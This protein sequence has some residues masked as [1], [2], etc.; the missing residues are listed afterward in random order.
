MLWSGP[1]NIAQVKIDDEGSLALLDSGSTINVVTPEFIKAHSLDMGPL[2]NLV[3]GTL[4]ING[5]VGLLSQP[6]GYVIVRV[7]VEGVKGYDED[8][9]ALVI[10]DLTAFGS[11]VPGTLGTPTIKQIVNIIKE[12]DIDEL[13]VSLNGSR[14]SCLLAGHWAELSLKN[15]ITARPIPD[16]M[17]LNEAVMMTKWEEIEAFSSQIVHG[18]TKTVLWGSN[19][20]ITPEK[21]EEPCLPHGLCV[22][23]TYTEMPNGSKCVAIVIKNQMAAPITIS[24]GIKINWVVAANRVPPVEVMSGTL[25]ELDETQGIQ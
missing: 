13:S 8:Q 6:L 9:V 1:E 21:G 24:K 16:F 23:N 14:I 22:A 3:D 19:M 15:N 5:F 25:E 20:Y 12:S 18:H 4:K 7:Q 10:P 11:R 17:N 2:S